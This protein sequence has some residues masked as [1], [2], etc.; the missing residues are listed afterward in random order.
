MPF[1]DYKCNDCEHLFEAEQRITADSL[2]T[3]PKCEKETLRRVINSAPGISFKGGGFYATDSRKSVEKKESKPEKPSEKP[4]TLET[5]PATTPK[6]SESK[7]SPP[8]AKPN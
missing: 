7:P 4:S 6:L 3:C 8:V 2:T 1:Y 5:K